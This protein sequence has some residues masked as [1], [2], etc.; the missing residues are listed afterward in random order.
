M[1]RDDTIRDDTD[2]TKEAINR[3]PKDVYDER[4]YRISRA[5]YLSARHE[6]LPKEEWMTLEKV[7]YL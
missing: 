2:V 4:N 3:L 5:M 6:I 7:K 1:M